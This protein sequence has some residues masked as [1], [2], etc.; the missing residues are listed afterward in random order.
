M[1]KKL[2]ICFIFVCNIL[3]TNQTFAQAYL[4]KISKECCKA[5]QEMP[6]G[7]SS[8][9]YQMQ[10]GLKML[11]IAA[12]YK[13]QLKKN[14][15]IDFSKIDED[16]KKLGELIG[17]KMAEVCP[18]VFVKMLTDNPD[19]L[20]EEE[21]AVQAE[22]TLAPQ[23]EIGTITK[24]E[25]ENFV[26]FS[27]KNEVGKTSKFYWLTHFEANTDIAAPYEKLV[28][29]K[30]NI[31]YDTYNFFD[32]KIEDYRQFFVITKLNIE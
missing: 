21:T 24:V 4:D 31:Q 30:V 13:K 1:K 23:S 11:A 25:N 27:V 17:A 19:M 2:L 29:K 3:L 28:G 7:M 16:G 6:S 26:V 8:E 20:K 18:E 12:P 5:M 9:E 10:L 32:P 22:E 15:N 14:H